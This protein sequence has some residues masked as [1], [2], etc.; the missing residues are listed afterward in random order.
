[1]NLLG[2]ILSC[3]ICWKSWITFLGC[4][5]LTYF[6]SSL[7][8]AKMFNCIVPGAKTTLS[9]ATHGGF[10]WSSSQSPSCIF[11]CVIQVPF[12]CLQSQS[13]SNWSGMYSPHPRHKCYIQIEKAELT[14]SI[15]REYYHSILHLHAS[16]RLWYPRS[17]AKDLKIIS[18]K[19]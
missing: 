2:L 11:K 3:C 1:V 17:R 12:I 6:V 16:S 10:L 19:V 5:S 13:R 18:A 14:F 15:L 7:F 9:A 4:P 8:Y